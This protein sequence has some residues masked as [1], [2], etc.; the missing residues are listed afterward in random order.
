V[1]GA[2]VRVLF[3]LSVLL[4][5]IS[6]AAAWAHLLAMP[7]KLTLSREQYLAVQQIYRGWALLG[8]VVFGA[9]AS[10]ATL[11]IEVRRSP[12]ISGLC[13][14]SA[15]CVAVSLL[16]FFVFTYPANQATSNWTM[17]PDNW[18]DLRRNW[19]YGHATGAILYFAALA[20]LTVALL[21]RG[22]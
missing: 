11:A 2:H 4:V 22:D 17:M 8:V 18:M 12:G 14:A 6:M 16:V 3:V 21:R 1:K 13:A 20:M 19:E 10:T 5:A 9:L 7:T 15:A